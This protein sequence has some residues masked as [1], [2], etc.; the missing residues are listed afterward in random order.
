MEEENEASWEE[1]ENEKIS[2][3]TMK[4]A[5]KRAHEIEMISLEELESLLEP[6]A[7]A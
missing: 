3:K 7:S 5:P 4:E 2:E 6:V 1:P